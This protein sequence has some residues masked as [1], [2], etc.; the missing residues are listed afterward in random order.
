MQIMHLTENVFYLCSSRGLNCQLNS[1]VPGGLTHSR[2]PADPFSS[3]GVRSTRGTSGALQAA[4]RQPLQA[5]DSRPSPG[6]A[7][8]CTAGTHCLFLMA[9]V[10]SDLITGLCPAGM[11]PAR[12]SHAG[13]LI[14][15]EPSL[16]QVRRLARQAYSC[17]ELP[18]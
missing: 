14:T 11:W 10:F 12:F 3:R 8:H 17:A 7:H 2:H 16:S 1:D 15:Q 5:F 6:A 4:L 9:G 18:L 13:A